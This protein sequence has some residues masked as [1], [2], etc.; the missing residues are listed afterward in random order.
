MDASFEN[1]ELLLRQTSWIRALARRLVDD[2]AMADDL[3]QETLLRALERPSRLPAAPRAWLAGILRNVARQNRRSEGRQTERERDAGRGERLPPT[4]DAVGLLELQRD[5]VEAVLALDEPYRSAVVERFF[6]NRPPREIAAKHGLPVSTV[7]SHVA[8]GIAQ[9]RARLDGSYGDR[10][11]WGLALL[12]LLPAPPL[13]LGWVPTA[14]RAILMTTTMTTTSKFLL[15]TLSAAGLLAAWYSTRGPEA[16]V[17]PPATPL[18]QARAPETPP[19]QSGELIDV[20]AIVRTTRVEVPPEASEEGVEELA[21]ATVAASAIEGAVLDPSGRGLGGMSIVLLAGVD[22]EPEAV[23]TSTASGSFTAPAPSAAGTLVI[24]LEGFSTLLAA[25]FDPTRATDGLVI[26]AARSESYAGRVFDQHGATLEGVRLSV[27][28]PQDYRD[29]LEPRL[30]RTAAIA[31]AAMSDAEGRFAFDDVPFQDGVALR[32]RSEGHR[33]RLFPLPAHSDRAMEVVLTPASDEETFLTGVVFDPVG[34]P[35]SG[36]LIGGGGELV[37]TDSAGFFEI[38]RSRVS[39]VLHA[40][41]AGFLPIEY[42]PI[43][44]APWPE[45]IELWLAEYPLEI[46]GR[47]IDV[48]GEPIVGYSVW[49]DDA[50]YFGTREE[51]ILIAESIALGQAS[52]RVRQVTDAD[53]RFTIGGLAAR[54]YRLR[55]MHPETALIVESGRIQAGRD[56]VVIEVSDDLYRAPVFGRVLGANGDPV[57]GVGV[58]VEARAYTLPGSELEMMVVG[59]GTTT[60]ADGTFVLTRV[61][62]SADMLFVSSDEV[63]RTAHDLREQD[64]NIEIVV[65][66]RVHV[67]VV[68]SPDLPVDTTMSILDDSGERVGLTR[69]IG[70]AYMQ[71]ESHGLTDGAFDIVSCVETVRTLVLSSEGVEFRRLSIR[72]IPGEVTR[73]EL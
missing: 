57:G 3:A 16:G 25:K 43:D 21:A 20:P 6:E 15:G 68:A 53:G 48:D 56:D 47:V 4:S 61:P 50:T 71:A 31:R 2:P 5:V 23:A 52:Y 69:R 65:Q 24:D 22:A 72:P 63:M 51:E 55:V 73:V 58:R 70:T 42:R 30:H 10:R 37:R 39:G 35:V 11:S 66:R 40:A 17:R 19:V 8:R 13:R 49:I 26:V 9:L 27:V 14:A 32:I 28:Q 67:H 64:A 38:G 18:Q 44:G 60:A 33:D 41:A 59:L 12:P 7:K 54:T 29:P 45:Y 36:A 1:P 62:L 46:A 34:E